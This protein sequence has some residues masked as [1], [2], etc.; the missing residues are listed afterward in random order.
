MLNIQHTDSKFDEG[1]NAYYIKHVAHKKTYTRKSHYGH[2][3]YKTSRYVEH[4]PF[5]FTDK[6]IDFELQPL[7]DSMDDLLNAFEGEIKDQKSG[8][9]AGAQD[10]AGE[11]ADTI[12]A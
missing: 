11:L 10:E 12:D 2:R 5:F 6:D 3:Y 1:K 7:I 8:H 9:I 4:K